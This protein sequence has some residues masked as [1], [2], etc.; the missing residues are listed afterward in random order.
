M[1]LFV[2]CIVGFRGDV[3]EAYCSRIDGLELPASGDQVGVVESRHGRP[4]S[5]WPAAPV[6]QH[7]LSVGLQVIRWLKEGGGCAHVMHGRSLDAFLTGNPFLELT[8]WK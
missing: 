4:L 3:A 8:T 2:S 5:Q 6:L 7:Q 1:L